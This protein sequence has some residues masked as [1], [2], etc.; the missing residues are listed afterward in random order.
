MLKSINNNLFRYTGYIVIF[1]LFILNI[2]NSFFWDTVQLGSQH[3]NYYLN[4]NFS[5]LLLP[6]SID[7]GHIP[8]FGMYLA[9]VWSFLGRTLIISHLAMLPFILGILWQLN[10]IVKKFF[11][12]KYSGLVLLLI[13]LDPTLLSQITLV[14]PDVPLVFFFLLSL[15]SILNN[16]KTLLMVGIFFLFITSMRGMMVAFCLLI[17]DLYYN[18]NFNASFKKVINALVKRSTIYLPSLILFICFSLYHYHVKGWI[19]YHDDSPW[20]ESFKPANL[21]EFIF[22]LGVLGWRILDFGRIGIWV[23]S[24][25]LFVKYRKEIFRDN[26]IRALF[27]IFICFLIILPLNMLWAK[28]LVAHRYLLP[29]FLIFSLLCAKILFSS[30][31]NT[32][33]KRILVFIWIAVLT[34]GNFWVYP[35][36]IAQGWDATLAHLPYYDLRKQAIQYLD[37]ENID[38]NEVVTFFPNRAPIDNIDLNGDQRN[39][40]SYKEKSEYVLYSNIYNIRDDIYDR[41]R[42]EYN[43]IKEFKSKSIFIKIY[44]IK[45]TNL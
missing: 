20:S 38:I 8:A 29:I 14:S 35:D 26:Q 31:V 36:K 7:S 24:L 40:K 18:V 19:G 16:N 33:L 25:V 27:F 23:V 39:F 21:T 9:L 5:S 28:N 3:A 17:I 15:N 13:L 1:S 43:L 10:E 37:T 2:Q 12:I 42:N 22:N 30:Y 6:N 34:T 4:T 45:A 44:K 11:R 32:N 41:L